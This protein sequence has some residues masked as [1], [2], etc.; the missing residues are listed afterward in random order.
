MS[1]KT[2]Y[3]QSVEFGYPEDAFDMICES[4]KE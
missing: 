4:Y 1:I 2:L 3:E